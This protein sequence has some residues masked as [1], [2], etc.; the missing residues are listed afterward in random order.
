M[1]QPKSNITSKLGFN[2]ERSPHGGRGVGGG[3]SHSNWDMILESALGLPKS[4]ITCQLGF[5]VWPVVNIT[6]DLLSVHARNL[7]GMVRV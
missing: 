1:G 6:L 5:Y 4:N 3:G 7:R 2:M